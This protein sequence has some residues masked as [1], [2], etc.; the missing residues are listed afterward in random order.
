LIVLGAPALPAAEAARRIAV[1]ADPVWLS[2]PGPGSET[3]IARDLFAADPCHV[4]RGSLPE[5]QVAWQAARA[6][7]ASPGAADGAVPIG[8]GWLAY[9]LARAWLPLPRRP[10]ATWPALEF[11]F[12][13]AVASRQ[14]SSGQV[15]IFACD[16]AAAARLADRLARPAE[17]TP[18]PGIG[19]YP[20]RPRTRSRARSTPSRNTCAPA[21]CTR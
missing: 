18:P 20:A 13:D 17:P 9:D 7:W 8:V 21:T 10:P 15:T 6:R 5:L 14:A 4:V 11:R 19:A 3:A 12:Y 2:S 1:G 16:A